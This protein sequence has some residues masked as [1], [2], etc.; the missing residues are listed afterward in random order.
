MHLSDLS[1]RNAKASGR[2]L[3]LFDGDGLYLLVKP[4]GARL[5]RFKYRVA[6]REKLLSFGSY[7]DVPLKT[8]RE[9]REEARKLLAAG[10]D[11]GVQRKVELTIQGDTF[12]AVAREWLEMQSKANDART[13]IKKKGRFEV[14]AFPYLGK[15]PINHI[16]APDLLAVL[17]KIEVRGKH[18]TAHRV[19]AECAAVFRF[20]ISTGRLE[21]DPSLSLRGALAP[22]VVTNRP[23]ITDPARIGELMRAIDGYRGHLPTEAALKLLP[24]TFVR[25]GELRLSQWPEF[26]LK[27]SEWRIPAARMKMREQHIVPLSTQAVVL[28]RELEPL[29]GSG[30]YVFP[31]I[32]ADDRAISDNTLNAALRRLGFTSDEMVSHGFRS[33]ASTCLNEKGWHP[34]I[35][36]L[37]LAHAE[38]NEVRSAYTRAQRLAERRTMMQAWADYLDSLKNEYQW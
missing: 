24:L 19:R 30:K 32:R 26:D 18:E 13:Y 27:A 4:N 22:V 35:I 23:A 11:P 1:I 9:L 38:R 14:F 2:P 7:R 8:A 37:Q 16:K 36:E 15:T 33:M 17:R 34:D 5:W 29:T 3:K 21:R 6:G 31:S 10:G 25:P 28:L 20:A 12:E